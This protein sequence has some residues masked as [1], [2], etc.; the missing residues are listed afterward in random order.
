MVDFYCS[1]DGYLVLIRFI[2]T[3]IFNIVSPILD[4]FETCVLM[5]IDIKRAWS[6]LPDFDE[7]S[8]QIT[9]KFT[10]AV[11]CVHSIVSFHFNLTTFPH[12][13][14]M[15]MFT[16]VVNY[17]NALA[18]S[19]ISHLFRFDSNL[20]IC[21]YLKTILI[22]HLHRGLSNFVANVRLSTEIYNWLH[23]GKVLITP[24]YYPF[25]IGEP[26]RG[27]VLSE[28]LSSWVTSGELQ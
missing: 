15:L 11:N 2:A 16:C 6:K 27:L 13:W 7:F 5:A 1:A 17:V 25:Q 12:A 24:V 22:G 4:C 18:Y 20:I 19:Q 10:F 23:F 3:D 14:I 9:N 21:M 8:D 26:S 28:T